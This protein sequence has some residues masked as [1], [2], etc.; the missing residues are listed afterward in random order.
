MREKRAKWPPIVDD[1]GRLEGRENKWS[2]TSKQ[3]FVDDPGRL[4]GCENRTIRLAL[5]RDVCDP[6]SLER[7]REHG[8]QLVCDGGG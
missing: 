5:P 7:V 6:D 1:P 8:L 3:N 4:E 2:L